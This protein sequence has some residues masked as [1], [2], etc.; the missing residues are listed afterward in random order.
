MKGVPVSSRST[1][2]TWLR[3]IACACACVC[4]CVC[5]CVQLPVRSC[6]QEDFKFRQREYQMLLDSY[7]R[8]MVAVLHAAGQFA[9]LDNL[10]NPMYLNLPALNATLQTPSSSSRNKSTGEPG[11][12]EIGSEG[13]TAKEPLLADVEDFIDFS[14]AARGEPLLFSSAFQHMR[15]EESFHVGIQAAV[16][17]IVSASSR[18]SAKAA[19][20]AVGAM[21]RQFGRH[22]HSCV[23]DTGRDTRNVSDTQ[24]SA[25]IT[26]VCVFV[27]LAK[28]VF[29]AMSSRLDVR[30]TLR[31][32]FCSSDD[33]CSNS[34]LVSMNFDCTFWKPYTDSLMH[35][36]S[37]HSAPL[38]RAYSLRAVTLL[39]LAS[40]ASTNSPWIV[41]S[42]HSVLRVLSRAAGCE[43]SA[44]SSDLVRACAIAA[45]VDCATC[46]P[47]PLF[48]SHISMF[49]RTA[50]RGLSILRQGGYSNAMSTAA[51]FAA[52][53]TLGEPP[54]SFDRAAESSGPPPA[55]T[56]QAALVRRCSLRLWHAVALRH[57]ASSNVEQ[58]EFSISSNVYIE[59]ALAAVTHLRAEASLTRTAA[60]RAIQAAQF[61][62]AQLNSVNGDSS[63]TESLSQVALERWN[64]LLQSHVE[65]IPYTVQG[66]RSS[67]DDDFFDQRVYQ[68]SSNVWVARNWQGDEAAVPPLQLQ[69]LELRSHDEFLE[70]FVPV[71][72]T[73]HVWSRD[74]KSRGS[75]DSAATVLVEQ[76]R[77]FMRQQLQC[78]PTVDNC[79]GVPILADDASIKTAM[80]RVLQQ[81]LSEWEI[82]RGNA[83]VSMA[84]GFNSLHT[85][86][87]ENGTNRVGVGVWME[88]EALLLAPNCLD[89]GSA[90]NGT[91]YARTRAARALGIL[92]IL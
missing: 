16:F 88:L 9:T 6:E 81:E 18:D 91:D 22:L 57:W 41:E 27:A 90:T 12:S 17:A 39:M 63:S 21:A 36:A 75:R 82:V 79:E 40:Q 28:I 38:V 43:S 1:R 58:Q 54:D 23:E 14:I 24:H 29:Q 72:V 86:E 25:S 53:S 68:K 48:I 83:A 30:T 59:M 87:R 74:H 2:V 20:K 71:L 33:P 35:L 89:R 51:H 32:R 34:P 15:S 52:I 84:V 10:R 73:G 66:V 3:I 8:V 80:Q 37:S 56:C 5:V 61:I 60:I 42:G 19:G 67:T 31:K 13:P 49:Q 11:A 4:V 76:Y 69:R 65:E 62:F 45:L 26:A 78:L 7:Y 77:A 64:D 50:S 70:A 55:S 46:L 47:T 85:Q 44:D 92:A